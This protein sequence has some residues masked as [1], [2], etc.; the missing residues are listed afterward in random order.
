ML[1]HRNLLTACFAALLALGLAACGTGG[2]DAPVAME[3]PEPTPAPEPVAVALPTEVPSTYA[4]PAAG[5]MTIPA[6]ESRAANDISFSCAAGGDDCTVTVAADGSVTSV[7][8]TVTASLTATAMTAL[9]TEQAEAAR[10][11]DQQKAIDDA[12]AEAVAAVG[13]VTDT[14]DDAEVKAAAEAIA[15]A[16]A[17]I[18][19]AVDVP[20]AARDA[21]SGQVA[22]LE[23]NFTGASESRALAMRIADQRQAISDT[24]AAAEK[25]I[26]AVGDESTDAEV[27]AADDAVAAARAAVDAADDLTDTEKLAATQTI[28]GLA[29]N[30][31][32]AKQSR[33]VAMNEQRRQNEINRLAGLAADAATAA[34]TAATEAENAATMAE[35]A[36]VGRA[37]IQTADNSQT[38][39]EN[40]R[41][42]AVLAR[43]DATAARTAADEAAAATTVAD[44]VAAQGRAVTAQQGAETH[45]GHVAGYRDQAVDAG[46]AEVKVVE[47]GHQVGD[48]AIEAGAA[49]S[50]VTVTVNGEMTTT[51]TGKQGD[52][53]KIE[54]VGAVAGVAFANTA[55]TPPNPNTAYVQQVAARNVNIGTITDSA[56]DTA[57]LML[58][59]HYWGTNTGERVCL[60]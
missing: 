6:G 16:K 41:T 48:T 45:Q 12:I 14:S 43:N 38:H 32:T 59:T 33:I 5:T 46:A 31:S 44:A 55:D 54:P 30:L 10:I 20:Q 17:A 60:R 56:D 15:A 21:A 24:I 50:V 53:A 39:A 52:I 36:A 1:T 13:R 2:D 25:A 26:G 18:A 37:L 28:A 22:T 19:A 29:D 27:K 23:T 3:D 42:H 34:E 4:A 47:D 9:A 58:V 51:D 40:A 11:A 8:G 7:G 57:R 35:N 49:R